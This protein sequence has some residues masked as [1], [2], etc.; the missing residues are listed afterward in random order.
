MITYKYYDGSLVKKGDKVYTGNL[1]GVVV[2]IFQPY[3]RNAKDFSCYNTGGVL[4]EEFTH[5]GNKGLILFTSL[6]DEEDVILLSDDK[7]VMESN[8]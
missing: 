8:F 1:E 6:D 4:I 5:E 2:E 3:T 7:L